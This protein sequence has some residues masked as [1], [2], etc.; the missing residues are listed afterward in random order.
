MAVYSLAYCLFE[1][2][3]KTN[4]TTNMMKVKLSEQSELK[5]MVFK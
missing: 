5:E 2:N 3:T 4:I 1:T